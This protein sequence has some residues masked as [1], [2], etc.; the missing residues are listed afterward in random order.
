M[1]GRLSTSPN[2]IFRSSKLSTPFRSA[3]PSQQSSDA[4]Q[5]RNVKLARVRNKLKE[6]RNSDVPKNKVNPQAPSINDSRSDGME[7][8][9]EQK[10][11]IRNTDFKNKL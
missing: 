5:D 9:E 6:R 1:F 10:Q 7:M 11:A 2:K 4:N 3:S 8:M